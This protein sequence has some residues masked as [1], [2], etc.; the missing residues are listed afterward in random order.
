MKEG[1]FMLGLPG[2]GKSSWVKEHL[3]LNKNLFLVSAD[4]IRLAHP[5]Y[6]PKNPELIHE[7][8]V[9]L[10]EMMV[11]DL[12]CSCDSFIMDG[13]GINN[14]YT[15]RIIEK[16]K[17]E[18]YY[19]KI[20]FINT[21]LDVCIQRNKQRI[22]N[23]ERFVKSEFIIDK[24]YKLKKSINLLEQICDEFIEIPYF[25]NKYVFCD[26]DGT[27]AEYQNLPLDDFGNIDFVRYNVFRHS[28]PVNPI[29]EKVKRLNSEIFILSASPNSICNLE[30]TD[31]AKINT[32]FVKEEN[33]YFVGNRNYKHVFLE[34]LLKKLKINANDC[35]VIDDDHQ[36]LEK[37]KTIGVN[38]VH[39]SKLLSNY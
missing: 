5:K 15:K 31:W 37:Y 19:I 16:C 38:T 7:E 29:I 18:G 11:Y 33:I 1:I 36:I 24:A 35:M 22:S 39:P 3:S 23:G 34:Q 9:G 27:L 30:K 13:G 6:D 32:P 2:S 14:S 8:C 4:E 25:T 17:T 10:A 28:K 26:L 12:I 21:P 20:V